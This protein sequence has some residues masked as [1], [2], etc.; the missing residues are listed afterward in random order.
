MSKGETKAGNVFCPDVFP[1][2]TFR[3]RMLKTVDWFLRQGAGR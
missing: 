1:V 2:N 3:L